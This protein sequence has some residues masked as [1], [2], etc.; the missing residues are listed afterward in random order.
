MDKILQ[1]IIEMSIFN[2]IS[3]VLIVYTFKKCLLAQLV[4]LEIGYN[5]YARVSRQ[6]S[7]YESMKV[8][9]K[10]E[11]FSVSCYILI[12]RLIV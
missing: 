11:I 2:T 6:K 7:S 4:K 12:N 10:F 9:C 1:F 8:C 5:F 3:D